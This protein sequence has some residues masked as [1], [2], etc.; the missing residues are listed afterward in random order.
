MV[1]AEVQH[2][3]GGEHGFAGDLRGDARAARDQPRFSRAHVLPILERYAIAVDALLIVVRM[4]ERAYGV[5]CADL[6]EV[7]GGTPNVPLVNVTAGSFARNV[8]MRK[9][10]PLEQRLGKVAIEQ[11]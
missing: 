5:V 1:I 10:Q 3:K 7:D 4:V 8:A 9:L 11:L 2:G 6:E